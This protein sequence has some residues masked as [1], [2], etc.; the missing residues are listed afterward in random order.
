LTYWVGSQGTMTSSKSCKTYR[1]YNV[2]KKR[3]F[4]T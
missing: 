3:K 1:N 2:D 4:Q